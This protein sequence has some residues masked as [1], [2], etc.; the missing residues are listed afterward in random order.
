M[1]V[2]D[3]CSI[4]MYFILPSF[5]ESAWMSHLLNL[6]YFQ[7]LSFLLFLTFCMHIGQLNTMI[8]L[9]HGNSCTPVE[10]KVLPEERVILQEGLLNFKNLYVSVLQERPCRFKIHIYVTYN[11]Q[12]I[13]ES[14]DT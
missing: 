12:I 5:I 3:L 11:I 8:S 2:L 9:H 7:S 14:L 1:E 10:I 13:I 4:S 6:D